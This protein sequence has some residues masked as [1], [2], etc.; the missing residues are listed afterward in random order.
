MITAY[1]AKEAGAQLEK[2]EFN[3]G[4]L[5]HDEVEINVEYCGIC[6]SDLSMWKNDWGMSEYPLVLG[7]EIVGTIG[8]L[9]S[10]V[11]KFKE[12][13]RVG[14]GWT[15]GSCM[16]CS[17][18][19]SGDHNLCGES[20]G[21]IVGRHGGFAD[22]VRADSSWAISIPDTLDAAKAGP[23]FC[24]GV[25]VF[26]PI[27]QSNVKPTDRV[28]V[29]GIG[30]LGHLA[31]QFLNAW[32]CDVTAFS[33]TPDKEQEAKQMGAHHFVNSRD[34][35]ALEALAGK[36]DF[37][38]VTVNADLPWDLYVNALAPK[39][40]LHLVGAANKIELTI[41]P[42]ISA[43]RSV[44]GSPIGS[45]E[46]QRQMLEFCGRHNIAPLVDEFPMDQVNEAMQFVADGKARYRAV[47][48]R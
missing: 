11:K 44:G 30:G 19:M 20:E 3:A 43:Q 31:L 46:V 37:I 25:T 33:T 26:N 10:G 41:F 21:T 2:F 48:K 16:G 6:H 8:K 5:G 4:E 38:L 47:L 13:D 1:A 40:K 36:F 23:L 45:P 17:Q 18:C 29:V 35:E 12:G 39:G 22:K 15:A 7:H 34:E 42:L 27:I 9:G 14:L 24:G 32:G 28:A